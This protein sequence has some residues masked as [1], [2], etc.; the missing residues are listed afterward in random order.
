MEIDG[1]TCRHAEDIASGLTAAEFAPGV[2]VLDSLPLCQ[3]LRQIPETSET[4]IIWLTRMVDGVQAAAAL[5]SGADELLQKPVQE[6]E[7]R[8]RVRSVVRERQLRQRVRELQNF[9]Q[10]FTD[11]LV[12]DIRSPLQVILGF[13]E[14]LSESS[15][16][17]ANEQNQIRSIQAAASRLENLADD[18]IVSTRLES[19]DLIPQSQAIDAVH[20][21]QQVADAIR[22]MAALKRVTIT[23]EPAAGKYTV[24]A[25]SGLIR[26]VLQIFLDN[27]IRFS[28]SGSKVLFRIRAGD[29][30]GDPVGDPP[31]DPV[32]DPPVD[33]V[34]DP[35]GD[36]VGDPPGDPVGDPPADPVGDPPVDPVGDP[37]ADP[38]GDPPADPVGDPPADPV[39]DPPADPVGDPP[40]DPVGNPAGTLAFE[41]TDRGDDVAED[42]R[43]L[44]FDLP[45]LLASQRAGHAR[46][47]SG[48]GL[49]LCRLVAEAHGGTAPMSSNPAGGSV[50]ILELPYSSPPDAVK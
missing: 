16:V 9:R 17:P 30:P 44:I 4:P 5:R 3:Q 36:P 23:L 46:H 42:E 31:G 1:Y 49:T 45:R 41:V 34:G 33:A 50:L 32:G 20:L 8:A 14:L 38:V 24:H 35:P 47:G 28:P 48:L 19:G 40:A 11:Q 13:S 10:D 37:P 26:R 43:E 7:I 15:D 18:L 25:D 21:A 22:P 29:P 2:I 27:S 12:H 39:G 6:V